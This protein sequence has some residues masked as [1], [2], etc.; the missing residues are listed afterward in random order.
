M[1]FKIIKKKNNFNNTNI[2]NCF[3]CM[4]KINYYIK[5]DCECHNYLHVD[6]L[7]NNNSIMNCLICKKKISKKIFFDFN[8]LQITDCVL[9][10]LNA[11]HN[12]DKI[13]NILLDNNNNFYSLF[14]YFITCFLITFGLL[15]PLIL[16]DFLTGICKSIFFTFYKCDYL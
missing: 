8:D 5:F 7:R 4:N 16:C 14:T 1:E 13:I 6:C 15:I 2:D 9:K 11:K 12:F 10:Y 3:I